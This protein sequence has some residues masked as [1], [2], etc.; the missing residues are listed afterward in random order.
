M[1]GSSFVRGRTFLRGDPGRARFFPW[2]LITLASVLVLGGWD[3]TTLLWVP[4]GCLGGVAFHYITYLPLYP[5]RVG[6]RN[7]AA[8]LVSSLI[9][10]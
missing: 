6:Q 2:F 4:C 1:A 8:Y 3:P 5:Q 7:A 9:S 10:R